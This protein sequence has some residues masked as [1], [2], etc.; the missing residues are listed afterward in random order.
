MIDIFYEFSF[1]KDQRRKLMQMKVIDKVTSLISITSN[2]SIKL[3][4]WL[5]I[6]RVISS[7]P[8]ALLPDLQKVT[9]LNGMKQA[10]LRFKDVHELFCQETLLALINVLTDDDQRSHINDSSDLW[11]LI[12]RSVFESRS[13]RLLRVGFE[14]LCNI[15]LLENVKTFIGLGQNN[16]SIKFMLAF[17]IIDQK[18][19]P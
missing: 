5:V 2:E 15:S 7:T 13:L 8:V 14:C 18:H 1:F 3:K 19:N 11:A 16:A 10:L 6:F 4:S 17:M 12:F 9:I